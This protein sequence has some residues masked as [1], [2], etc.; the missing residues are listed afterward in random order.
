[1]TPYSKAVSNRS[2]C[3]ALRA[4]ALQSRQSAQT[5]ARMTE[6]TA[7]VPTSQE[8]AGMAIAPWPRQADGQWRVGDRPLSRV[9]AE[10]GGTPCYLLDRRRVTARVAELRQLLPD[11]I[12]I[13]YAMKANPLPA[14]VCH[15]ASLVD[16]IDVASGGEMRVAL[17]SWHAGPAHQFC[18]SG[19]IR[20][21]TDAGGCSRHPAQH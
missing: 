3:C 5:D 9:V 16:G 12:R 10:V 19:Q 8:T 14:L 18:R 4:P 2:R 11:C 7:S 15:M 13:H 17:D 6:T 20:S 21:G 1:M